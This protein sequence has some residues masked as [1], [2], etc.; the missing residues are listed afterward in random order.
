MCRRA[1]QGKTWN[2]GG[3]VLT[4][5]G[6]SAHPHRF[7]EEGLVDFEVLSEGGVCWD[8][9]GAAAGAGALNRRGH[10]KWSATW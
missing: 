9:E 10:T 7:G 2:I 3:K 8:L 5:P 4:R 6:R 1:A